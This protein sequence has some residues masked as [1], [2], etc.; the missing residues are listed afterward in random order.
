VSEAGEVAEFVQDDR[1]HQDNA[2]RPGQQVRQR[3]GVQ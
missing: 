3:A 2:V 1:P